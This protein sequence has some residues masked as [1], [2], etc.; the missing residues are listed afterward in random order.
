MAKTT[1]RSTSK[2]ERCRRAREVAPVPLSELKRLESAFRK[3]HPRPTCVGWEES[4]PLYVTPPAHELVP[5]AWFDVDAVV[6]V[7]RA[8]CSFKHTKGR[9]SRRP[10]VPDPWQ[11]VWVIAPAFGWKYPTNH[12]DPELA[13]TRIIRELYVEIPRKNGKSTLSSG[14]ALVLLS[15]DGEDGAEVYAAAASRDQARVVFDQSKLLVE[16][17]RKLASRLNVMRSL[18]EH[19]GTGGFYRVLSKSAEAAHGLNVHGAVI[20]ELHVHKRRDLVDAIETGT[21]ARAQ[22]M[23]ITITTAD[24]GEEGTIYDEKHERVRKCANRIVR[25]EKFYGVIWAA[26]DDDDPFVESTWRKANPGLGVSPT[27]AYMRAEAEKARATASYYPVFCRLHLN[28]RIRQQTRFLSLDEWD[29]QGNIQIVDRKQLAGRECYGGLDLSAT[30]DLTA[31]ELFFPDDDHQGGRVLSHLWMPEADLDMRI[32]R[33]QVPYDQWAKAGWLTL[34]EGN[35]VD[36]ERVTAAIDAAMAEFDLRAIHHDR[37]QAGPVVQKLQ[38]LGIEASPVP[39]TYGGMSAPTQSLERLVKLGRLVHGGHPV[40]RWM[41]D[42]VE[43]IRDRSNPDNMRPVKPDR[44][45]SSKRVDGI[46]ALVMALDGW[47]RRPLEDMSSPAAV[48]GAGG[49]STTD[50][51]FFRPSGRLNL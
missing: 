18:I 43:V 29:Q 42:S 20:D 22:P 21:G 48:S 32:E 4:A 50:G 47:M 10:L 7:V 19:P 1:T 40:L 9:W 39:Q 38:G 24:E 51:D 25:I 44:A 11:I 34:T 37:W 46:T 45:K 6:R 12:P 30:T 17:N 28:R 13:G 8:L 27:L 41:A 3:L 2:A 26:A 33:D 16:T 49:G 5:G 14:L 15:A 35:V 36:Y 31:F 23:V